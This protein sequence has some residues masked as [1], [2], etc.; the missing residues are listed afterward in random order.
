MKKNKLLITAIALSFCTF[1]AT[2]QDI[3]FSQFYESTILRNPALTGIFTDDYKVSVQYRNQ[4]S[5]ISKP[6]VTG[7]L[8]FE[9]KIPVND[10]SKDFFS[11]GILAFYDKAGSIDMKTLS[12]YPSVSFN[13]SFGNQN[14][15]LLSVGFTGGYL[16]RSFD[17]SKMTVDNQYQ[18]GAYDPN[19]ATNENITSAKVNYWDVGAGVA[20]SS[21]AGEYSEISYFV[22]VSGYHFSKPRTS[23]YNNELIR[24]EMRWNGTAGLTYRLNENWGFMLQG[25]YTTQGKYQ[26]IIA[27]GLLNW[28]KPTERQS[29]PLFI[30]YLGAF[31]RVGDALI[32]VVKMDYMRYS[33]GFSYDLNVSGLKAAT[34]M[35]G[36]YELSVVKTGLFSDPK[37]ERSRTLCPNFQW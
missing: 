37:W 27:G 19:S 13:K 4:W 18:N 28:K 14:N 15:S 34:N 7:Q 33:F 29:E 31:Y 6:F 26:E 9:T 12:V 30:F 22:G 36:G 17:P 3:H 2:A 21:G 10:E 1:K 23:F 5:S 25:N 20:F 24:L 35:R 8:S 32:P 16:Q 11:A